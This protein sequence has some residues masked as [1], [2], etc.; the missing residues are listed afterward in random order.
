M[1]DIVPQIYHSKF[2]IYGDDIKFYN[3]VNTLNYVTL[4]RDPIRVKE[5]CVGIGIA[6]NGKKKSI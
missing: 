3:T 2:S 1:N 4:L 5:L 6:I